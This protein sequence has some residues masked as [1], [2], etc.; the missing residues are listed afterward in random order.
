MKIVIDGNIGCGKSTV[1]KKLNDD[2]RIP[3][4]LEPLH[5][6]DTLLS[7]FYDDPSKW[8][9]PFN[10]QVLT[11]FHEWRNNNFPAIYERSPLSC[12]YVF[13]QLNHEMGHVH[14]EELKIFDK[15][16]NEL[17]WTPD[18]C[19]YI[20]TDPQICMD[21]MTSRG[22]TCEKKVPLDYLEKVHDKYQE[23]ASKYASRIHII[24]GNRD[25][26]LVYDDVVT[27]IKSVVT[28]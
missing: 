11:D 20:K 8:A 21:R 12:R 5:K 4:F 18:I 15:I 16:F 28:L 6:W 7:L 17:I 3:I 24:D 22:R 9:F 19:I 10:L 14:P 26:Q 23:L 25:S 13:T 27:I 2:F 1:I